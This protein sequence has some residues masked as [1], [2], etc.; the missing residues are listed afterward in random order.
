MKCILATKRQM[1]QTFTPTG[2]VVPVTV[3]EAGPCVVTRLF[4]SPRRARVQLGFLPKKRP[5]KSTKKTP[6]AFRFL[7]EFPLT[8]EKPPQVGETITAGA[9][10][11]GDAV[12]VTGWSKG[13]GFTGVIKRHHF[14]GQAATH[15]TKDQLRMSGSIGATGPQRVF[16]GTRMAGRMGVA[17]TT[18]KHLTVVAVDAAKNLLA[19]SGALPGSRGGL[20]IVQGSGSSAAPRTDDAPKSS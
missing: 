7:R 6:Q 5:A 3:V 4:D 20:L 16:R 14:H 13:K 8:G 2:S 9:F 15:G 12:Q 1:T 17:R 10:A 19:I 18:V 11:P